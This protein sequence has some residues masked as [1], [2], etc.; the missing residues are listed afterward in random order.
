MISFLLFKNYNMLAKCCLRNS[1]FFKSMTISVFLFFTVSIQANNNYKFQEA[2]NDT[3]TKLNHKERKAER[4]KEKAEGIKMLKENHARFLIKYDLVF[5]NLK[6][7][8]TVN[9]PK[10]ILNL[11]L[12]LEDNLGLPSQSSFSSLAFVYRMTKRSGLY[13]NYYGINRSKD[14]VTQDDLYFLGDTIPAGSGINTYF[15]TQIVSVGYMLSALINPDAFLGFYA[16]LYVISL[17]TGFTSKSG[18]K[19]ENLIL[20]MPLP[21]F[22]FVGSFRLTKHVMFYGSMG[23]FSLSTEDYGGLI[24]NFNISLG[25]IPVHWLSINLSYTEFNIRVYNNIRREI[26]AIVEYNFRGPAVGLAFKF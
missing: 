16:N 11:S 14:I 10:G 18:S 3:T 17:K 6:T 22:G 26:D 12:S 15:N 23:V 13:L 9:G 1:L 24:S 19:A 2:Y 20:T 25:Y 8:V 21:N 7:R 5:A 4:K